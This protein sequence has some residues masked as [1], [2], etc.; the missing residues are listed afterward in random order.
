MTIWKLLGISSIVLFFLWLFFA[1]NKIHGADFMRYIQVDVGLIDVDAGT[2]WPFEGAKFII[3]DEYGNEYGNTSN[4]NWIIEFCVDPDNGRCELWFEDV[5]KIFYISE[6]CDSF[7]FD[8]YYSCNVN[9]K[10]VQVSIESDE[11]GKPYARYFYIDEYWNQGSEVYFSA[12]DDEYIFLNGYRWMLKYKSN[13]VDVGLIDVDA[14]TT[15]W[16]FANAKFIIKDEYGNEYVYTS[17]QDWIIE[18][19]VDFD[20]DR[21]DFWYEDIWK[22]FYISEDCDDIYDQY[23]NTIICDKS[24]VKV[25]IESDE[26]GEPYAR[27]FYIDDNL[28]PTQEVYP[29]PGVDDKYIFNNKKWDDKCV[30]IKTKV[31][32]KIGNENFKFDLRDRRWSVIESEYSNENWEVEWSLCDSID[33]RYFITQDCESLTHNWL[34][35]DWSIVTVNINGESVEYHYD[36]YNWNMGNKIHPCFAR[37]NEWEAVWWILYAENMSYYSFPQ[38]SSRQSWEWWDWD[39]YANNNWWWITTGSYVR[40]P[41]YANWAFYNSMMPVHLDLKT[42]VELDGAEIQSW[43]FN[44]KLSD[45]DSTISIASNNQSGDI[46]FVNLNGDSYELYEYSSCPY[47]LEWQDNTGENILWYDIDEYDVQGLL[48][49]DTMTMQSYKI[50]QWSKCSNFGYYICDDKEINVEPEISCDSAI[51]C[52]VEYSVDGGLPS[53]EV[54]LPSFLNE[55]HPTGTLD[56]KWK[57]SGEW[58]EFSLIDTDTHMQIDSVYSDVNWLFD[59]AIEYDEEDIGRHTYDIVSNSRWLRACNTSYECS[60]A[61]MVTLTVNITDEWDGNLKIEPEYCIKDI[62]CSENLEDFIFTAPIEITARVRSKVGN[63]GFKFDLRN[64]EWTIVD[65]GY[66]SDAN[67][68]LSRKIFDRSNDLYFITQDCDEIVY[69]GLICDESIVAVKIDWENIMYHFDT[70]DNMNQ[71]LFDDRAYHGNGTVGWW[72]TYGN[73]RYFSIENYSIWQEYVVEGGHVDYTTAWC[74]SSHEIGRNLYADYVESDTDN[75]TYEDTRPSNNGALDENSYSFYNK[76]RPV[77]VEL[78]SKVELLWATLSS[79][80][81]DFSFDSYNDES[82]DIWFYPSNLGWMETFNSYDF[83][84]KCPG[85]VQLSCFNVENIADESTMINVGYYDTPV[86]L[87]TYHYDIFQWS[88]CEGYGYYECDTRMRQVD[89]N[90][91]CNRYWCSTDYSIDWND[92]QYG[93]VIEIPKFVNEY[94]TIDLYVAVSNWDDLNWVDSISFDLLKNGTAF[95]TSYTVSKSSDWKM[96]ITD[97]PKYDSN[98]TEIEYSIDLYE[99][100]PQYGKI[101]TIENE[102]E[103]TILFNITLI[104]NEWYMLSWDG[105]TC[106]PLTYEVRHFIKNAWELSY[107]LSGTEIFTWIAWEQVYFD[108]LSQTYPSCIVYSRGSLT[109]D[110]NGPWEI[111]TKTDIS[112]DGSTVINLYYDRNTYTVDLSRDFWI[113]MVEWAGTYECGQEVNIRAYPIDGYHFDMWE[114]EVD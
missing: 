30:K 83:Q 32:S 100:P 36:Y 97:L 46:S 6:D 50:S 47:T 67:W 109:W 13:Q 22:I 10:V 82:G 93:D 70:Y 74:T 107:T 28:Y 69:P 113:D 65:S 61:G 45:Y 49:G 11:S 18:F 15:K 72:M 56:I 24:V 96:T 94:K 85:D 68:F 92:Y 39:N 55:Y 112:W 80:M 9:G 43:M 88:K 86:D 101:I 90:L 53:D 19:C 7:D 38:Y 104:C 89:I 108:D 20:N 41:E 4:E 87:G 2:K 3:K 8:G 44:F 12:G 103:S 91:S 114:G 98:G 54:E 73:N 31:K 81:F 17:T 77:C 48:W 16:P 62:G 1:V 95:P 14:G 33:D 34:L 79:G 27:Y 5:W 29:M 75:W 111:E 21:C 52:E 76:L 23:G 40:D 71:F 78:K 102:W 63:A 51:W 57:A 105:V 26:W 99:I 66:R 59:F 110:E 64:S 84:G 25:S 37:G 58:Y 42:K 35:C 106:V 60:D